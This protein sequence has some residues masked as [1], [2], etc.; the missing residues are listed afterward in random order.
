MPEAHEPCCVEDLHVLSQSQCYKELIY[1]IPTHAIDV[2]MRLMSPRASRRGNGAPLCDDSRRD[3]LGVPRPDPAR[4]MRLGSVHGSMPPL[5]LLHTEHIQHRAERVRVVVIVCGGARH[6]LGRAR[7]AA[8]A[9]FTQYLLAVI[10]CEVAAAL[11]RW[12]VGV[13]IP[14]SAARVTAVLTA[15]GSAGGC[16]GKAP[17]VQRRRTWCAARRGRGAAPLARRGAL[18]G[19][20]GAPGAHLAAADPQV[21]RLRPLAGTPAFT[22]PRHGGAT[23]CNAR[24]A[25]AAAACCRRARVAGCPAVR[26]AGC[27]AVCIAG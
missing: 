8:V 21:S 27:P 3:E 10:R 6:F 17:A 14:P 2:S 25:A 22:W 4:P 24:A 12:R 11:P 9:A 16:D 26:V 23:A 20:R 13:A 19:R 18:R 1:N 7:A 15:L 5:L